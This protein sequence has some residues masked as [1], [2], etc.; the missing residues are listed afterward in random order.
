MASKNLI[1]GSVPTIIQFLIV[2][3]ILILV[4]LTSSFA[5]YVFAFTWEGEL[6]PDEFDNWKFAEVT[7]LSSTKVR[8]TIQNP[9]SKATVQRIQITIHIDRTLLSYRYFKRGEIYKYVLNTKKDR[10]ERRRYSVKK[11]RACMQ[12]HP[13]IGEKI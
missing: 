1:P 2:A 10:Y 13:E 6:N 7:I 12:C 3:T 9:D 8:V 4:L 5:G 11:R